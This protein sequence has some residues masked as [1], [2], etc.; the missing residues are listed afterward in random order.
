MVRYLSNL[1]CHYV[2]RTECHPSFSTKIFEKLWRLYVEVS[3]SSARLLRRL[4]ARLGRVVDF[5]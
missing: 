1:D 4:L 2:V 3:S 5:V